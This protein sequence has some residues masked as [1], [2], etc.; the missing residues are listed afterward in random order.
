MT[1]GSTG[2]VCAVTVTYGDRWHYV[3]E[4]VRAVGRQTRQVDRIVI[5]AN[6]NAS[7]QPPDLAG[8]GS[9]VVALEQNG[10]SA[11]GFRRGLE[12]AS[13]TNCDLIWLL[14]D[15]N[16]PEPDALERLLAA[17]ACLGN[18]DTDCFAS[19]RLKRPK[20][21]AAAMGAAEMAVP[22]DSFM[23]LQATRVLDR[24]RGWRTSGGHAPVGP[25][26]A[27]YPV[28]RVEYAIFGGLLL[29]PS[30]T[31]TIGY[32]DDAYFTYLDDVDYTTRIV[33]AGGRIYL[34][35]TSI[36]DD[37]DD[38]WRPRG[39]PAGRTPVMA[40]LAVDP[41]RYYYVVRNSVYLERRYFVRSAWRYR[42]NMAAFVALV[43]LS[44]LVVN[45]SVRK[46]IARVRLV[47][48][49]IADGTAGR[50]GRLDSLPSKVR[51]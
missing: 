10:G 26:D 15:D 39:A 21:L 23:R 17:R 31:R 51:S 41:L 3:Q 6:G 33:R 37:L 29:S 40:N 28:R 27:K 25:A 48:A 1:I 42:L 18:R 50:M 8:D 5:V 13:A 9:S 7:T 24:L 22:P 34:V 35:S 44:T 4:V 14:D 38:T 12:V 30:W 47:L 2:V 46:A 16:R 45:L 36:V 49:A 19:L 11:A 20:H 43:G 32:P